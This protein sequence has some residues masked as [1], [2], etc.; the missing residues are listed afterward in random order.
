MKFGK[1]INI[2]TLMIA[3]TFLCL[4]IYLISFDAFGNIPQNYKLI[5]GSIIIAYGAFRAVMVIL[6]MK[7]QA[8]DEEV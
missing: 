8:A 2:F 1:I 5:F 6:K 4:G 3:I 7:E